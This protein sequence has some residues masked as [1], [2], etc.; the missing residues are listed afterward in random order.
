MQKKCKSKVDF[1]VCVQQFRIRRIVRYDDCKVGG[2]DQLRSSFLILFVKTG[3]RFVEQ[4][5]VV[6]ERERARKR[7]ALL[8]ST[9]QFGCFFV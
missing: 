3:K 5:N 2:C 6:R 4:N 9:G 8:L 1:S 7:D